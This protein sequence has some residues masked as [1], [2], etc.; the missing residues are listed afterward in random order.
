M[1]QVVEARLDTKILARVDPSDVVQEAQMEVYRRLPD[2]LARRPMPFRLWLRKTAQERMLSMRRRYL[3]AKGRALGR[4]MPLPERSSLM[5]AKP[6]LAAELTPSQELDQRELIHRV[7]RAV[8]R[9]SEAD[10]EILLLVRGLS[11]QEVAC[12]LDLDPQT[13]SKRY[14][15]AVLRLQRLLGAES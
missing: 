5:L 13:A 8:A 14:G 2:Y 1:H 9:L 4:E 12:L 10:Q 7:H 15:R 11:N 6:F 3:E